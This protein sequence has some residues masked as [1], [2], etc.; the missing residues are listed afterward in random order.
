LQGFIK[1]YLGEYHDNS[2]NK[3]INKKRDFWVS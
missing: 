1:Y 2:S 3:K